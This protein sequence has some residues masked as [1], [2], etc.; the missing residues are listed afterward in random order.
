[1]VREKNSV[2]GG[3]VEEGAISVS[4]LSSVLTRRI[5]PFRAVGK[6]K[7]LNSAENGGKIK[8]F[9]F[10][11]EVLLLAKNNRTRNVETR[12]TKLNITVIPFEVMG[13]IVT[14]TLTVVWLAF[15]LAIA[16]VDV[17]V[18]VRSVVR[19]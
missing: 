11:S 17:F 14:M 5:K 3:E 8:G 2:G 4:Q 18:S 15:V 6:I 16:A 1:M 13:R 7:I 19:I 10:V 9:I 12:F